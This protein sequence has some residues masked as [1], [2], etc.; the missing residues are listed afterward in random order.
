MTVS[1][2][3]ICIAGAGSIGC[4]VGGCLASGGHRVALLARRSTCEAVAAHG[5]RLTGYEGMDE[6]VPAAQLA[7]SDDP[8]IMSGADI[9][10]VT[11]KGG[12]T[13]AIAD[14]VAIHA[15]PDATVVSLQN[16]VDNLALLRAKLPGRRVLGGM[17]PFNVLSQ[18]DGHFHR[19][20]SGDIVLEDDPSGLAA[21]L[22]VPLLTLLPTREID[23][24][25]WG[26][27]LINLNNALNAL[28]GIP[29][30]EQ[31]AHRD[32]RRLLADQMAEALKV[33]KAAR[34][35]VVP[36][37]Q[38]PPGVTPFLL[39]L[40]DRLFHLLLGRIL[41][42]DPQARSSMWDDLAW[43]RKTEIGQLQGVIVR[44]ADNHGLR[45]PLSARVVALVR[46]AEARGLGS[47]G[48]T[49]QQI[50]TMTVDDQGKD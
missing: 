20:T 6:R 9:V 29:L 37:T 25:Q 39:R 24:V 26:K 45:A 11:V 50:R 35:R 33:M 40:P 42:I 5:L 3:S 31:L 36:M 47:P 14:L 8:S 2:L 49:P 41:Q 17:V 18:G 10:L 19:A 22:S 21:R 15:R 27:L 16:G 4:Y 44:L 48:L 12:D 23:A 38:L 28:A 7:L 1:P 30:R 32:W 43:R 13:A 34:I 46:A